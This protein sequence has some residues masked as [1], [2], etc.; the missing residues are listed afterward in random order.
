MP[1]FSLGILKFQ[2]LSFFLLLF[3]LVLPTNIM[4]RM[5][6]CRATVSQQGRHHYR[7]SIYQDYFASRPGSF[8]GVWLKWADM[9]HKTFFLQAKL[10]ERQPSVKRLI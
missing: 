7:T 3:P 10:A 9:P 2:Y 8:R 6:L 4:L 5:R 1:S